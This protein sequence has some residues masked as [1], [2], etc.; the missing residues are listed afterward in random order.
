[1]MEFDRGY[2]LSL[3]NNKDGKLFI[4]KTIEVFNKA[5]VNYD[6]LVGSNYD[7]SAKINGLKNLL[8]WASKDYTKSLKECKRKTKIGSQLRT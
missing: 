1:M 5:L 7:V 3:D 4:N 8:Y 2:N 6:N